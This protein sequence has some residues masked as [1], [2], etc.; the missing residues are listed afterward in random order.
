MV[1][2]QTCFVQVPLHLHRRLH[3]HVVFEPGF[4]RRRRTQLL[5][6]H[7]ADNFTTMGRSRIPGQSTSVTE[8]KM[9][10]LEAV[11]K[12]SK[13]LQTKNHASFGG[14][15]S[16]T[17]R[18]KLQTGCRSTKIPSGGSPAHFGSLAGCCADSERLCQCKPVQTSANLACVHDTKCAQYRQQF[19]VY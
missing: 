4:A 17:F 18:F 5:M 10:D 14:S 3:V 8:N 7:W 12:P 9:K 2:T 1:Q 6:T 11:K 16:K 19:Q 15:L 13:N